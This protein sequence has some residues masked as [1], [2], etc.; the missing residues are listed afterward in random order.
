MGWGWA[1]H[2]PPKIP[3][4]LHTLLRT[5]FLTIAMTITLIRSAVSDNDWVCNMDW[6]PPLSQVG[7]NTIS[8]KQ[9]GN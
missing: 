7:N 8:V 9:V 6:V 3:N 1:P 5:T 4:L 2:P